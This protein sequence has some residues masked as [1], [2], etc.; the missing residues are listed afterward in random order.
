MFDNVL[1]LL[2]NYVHCTLLIEK[3]VVGE[4]LKPSKFY[5]KVVDILE[6]S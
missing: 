4:P 6:K 1:V 5:K 2:S 3:K